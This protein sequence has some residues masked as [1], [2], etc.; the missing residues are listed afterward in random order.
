MFLVNN[1]EFSSLKILT[2]KI[3]KT[4]CAKESYSENCLSFGF[5]CL[6]CDKLNAKSILWIKT[7]N[8]KESK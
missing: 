8:D 4:V 6:D 2:R 7:I 5:K 1:H 3:S